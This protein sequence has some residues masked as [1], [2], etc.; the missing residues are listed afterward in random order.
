MKHLPESQDIDSIQ[1]APGQLCWESGT[2]MASCL[3]NIL[4]LDLSDGYMSHVC[5]LCDNLLNNILMLYT[6]YYI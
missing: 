5:L 6:F 3:G 4:F 1:Q 2:W